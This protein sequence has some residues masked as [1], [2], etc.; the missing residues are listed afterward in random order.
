MY[1]QSI[2][3]KSGVH[4]Q[5][6]HDMLDFLTMIYLQH[7]YDCV[8]ALMQSCMHGVFM[9]MHECMHAYICIFVL[10]HAYMR[11]CIGAC[12]CVCA[13]VCTSVSALEAINDYSHDMK[14]CSQ[15]TNFYNSQPLYV[16]SAINNIDR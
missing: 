2:S 1:H 16:A 3:V 10:M 12:T 5:T 11:I 15:I 13:C 9:L 6:D 8:F 7:Q 14:L 4:W